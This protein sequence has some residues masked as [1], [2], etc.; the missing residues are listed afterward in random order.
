[1]KLAI[2]GGGGFRVPLIYGALLRRR[3]TLAFDEL[4]LHDVD[5]D[6]LARI[7]LVLEGQ[8]AEHG[9]R[10]P[11]RATGDLDDAIEGADF[12]FSAIRV[13]RLDARTVDESVPLHHGVLGQETT[14]PGGIG[15]ALRTI[16]VMLEL[17]E[18]MAR[19]APAAWLVNFTN[20]AGMVTEALQTVLGDRA[21]GICDSPSALCRRV[22]AA[23]GRRPEELWFDYF[24]LNHLGW[25]RGVRDRTGDL[26]P[27]LLA[28]DQA[29]DSLE[30]GRLFGA[31]WLRSIGLIPNEYLYYYDYAADT[32]DAIRRSPQPRGAYLL[33]QQ[34]AFYDAARESPQ[35][36]LQT[37][38]A[39]KDERDRSYMAEARSAAGVNGAHAQEAGIGGYEG[40]AM[41]V[42]DAITNNTGTVLIVNA[43]NRSALPFLD[44]RAVVEVPC[45]VGAAGAQPIAVGPVPDHARALIETIKAV[46]RAT[47]EAATTGSTA[48]AVKALALHPLVPSVNAAREI[49]SG[50]RERLPDLEE[51]FA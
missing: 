10:L 50:Y 42:V 49:F 45:V 43:A 39:S 20:P 5:E 2:V 25:L 17:A 47:I 32:V 4:V 44:A 21:I 6:R 23:L 51:R 11:F 8:A 14:G 30:E 38:R 1:M 27:G 36:A 29:L 41:A 9:D 34:A 33:E 26:M 7:S 31:E 3:S 46:E 24:S 19:R 40:E 13:G 22:A 37:W 12:V 15:F 48:L 28:D 16:P 35:Q 18:T